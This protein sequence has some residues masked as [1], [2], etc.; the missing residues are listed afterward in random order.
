MP[1]LQ[2]ITSTM[3]TAVGVGLAQLKPSGS[4]GE[5]HPIC[6]EAQP[7]PAAQ[8]VP[9]LVPPLGPPLAPPQPLQA[10]QV[11]PPLAPAQG[12]TQRPS[13]DDVAVECTVEHPPEQTSPRSPLA[14]E[15]AA[16][17]AAA[18]VAAAAAA[19]PMLLLHTPGWAH[20]VASVEA[21]KGLNAFL[22]PAAAALAGPSQQPAGPF[23]AGNVSAVLEHAVEAMTVR[24]LQAIGVAPKGGSGTPLLALPAP[25]R[26]SGA[27]E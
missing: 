8:V 15:P 9:P 22:M 3:Q 13:D 10:A 20:T 21:R 12:L 19:S 5:W 25:A 6:S 26:G 4:D 18:A 2:M 7:P 17:V 27:S 14:H 23:G 1:I 24:V 11:A 16:A